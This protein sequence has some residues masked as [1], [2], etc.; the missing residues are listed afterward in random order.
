MSN[1]SSNIIN[2]IGSNKTQQHDVESKANE[3][4]MKRPT[5]TTDFM[6]VSHSPDATIDVERSNNS[7][8]ARMVSSQD[9]YNVLYKEYPSMFLA[10][11]NAPIDYGRFYVR[12][13]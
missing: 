1:R 2:F 13:R 5:D 9:E 11:S 6:F 12:R 8:V 3:S 4:Y 7:Q 10:S